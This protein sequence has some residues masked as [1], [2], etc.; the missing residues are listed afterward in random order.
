MV[1]ITLSGSPEEVGFQHGKTLAD[2]IHRNIAFYKS[3]FLSN[4]GDEAKVLKLAES[5][6]KR[7]DEFNPN[8]LMEI[9][10]VAKG[11]GVSESL[12]LY[13]LNSRTDLAITK[14][15]NDCTAIVFPQHKIIGQTWDW[16]Q[17]LENHSVIM[18]IEFPHKP[19]S[20]CSEICSNR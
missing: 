13:A 14:N 18:E 9:N 8:Y 4:L 3:I 6:K 20:P 5:F 19:L 1:K 15:A 11:A 16:A 10:H 17:H 2:Q 12:W 7:I